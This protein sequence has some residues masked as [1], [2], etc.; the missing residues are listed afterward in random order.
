MVMYALQSR[1]EQEGKRTNRKVQDRSRNKGRKG[2]DLERSRTNR[3]DRKRSGSNRICSKCYK[4][5]EWKLHIRNTG[6]FISE[7]DESGANLMSIR[8]GKI[9]NEHRIDLERTG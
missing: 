4:D 6:L 1:T 5:Q 9:W 7:Q 8:R 3:I 2:L